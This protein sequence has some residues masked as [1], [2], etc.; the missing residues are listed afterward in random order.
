MKFITPI[1]EGTKGN[2]QV[3]NKLLEAHNIENKVPR[4]TALEAFAY[5]DELGIITIELSFEVKFK[6]PDEVDLNIITVQQDCDEYYL[7]SW[8]IE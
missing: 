4:G 2:V 6:N 3:L 7:L 8:N 5:Y 1:Y